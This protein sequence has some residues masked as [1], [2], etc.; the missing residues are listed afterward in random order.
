MWPLGNARSFRAQ[1]SSRSE[2]GVMKQSV[3]ATLLAVACVAF[4][5]Q[6]FAQERFGGI[7]GTVTDESGGVM[8]GATIT[9]TN[10]ET[11]AVRST[12]SG[13]DGVYTVT[14]LDPGRY[15]VTVSLSG[16]SSVD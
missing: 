8:P 16:F 7:V 10:K 2:G 9:I 13:T 15:N 14:D 6:A 12:V 11:G 5:A 3:L 1:G 4:G